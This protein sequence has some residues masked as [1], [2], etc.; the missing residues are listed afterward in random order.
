RSRLRL[1]PWNCDEPAIT[2]A[3]QVATDLKCS[4]ILTPD[5]DEGEERD[6][7]A[8]PETDGGTHAD[9]RARRRSAL[10]HQRLSEFEQPEAGNHGP[11]W[12]RGGRRPVEPR[13]DGLEPNPV[14]FRHHH[15]SDQIERMNPTCD[16]SCGVSLG[17]MGDERSHARAMVSRSAG[18][19]SNA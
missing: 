18:A 14:A 2:L 7:Q 12:T 3:D 9:R 6:H 13:F 17:K 1:F 4:E 15:P 10:V 16:R 11:D 5:R 19:M 8:V